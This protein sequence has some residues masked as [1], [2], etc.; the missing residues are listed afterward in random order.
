MTRSF[1]AAFFFVAFAA[2]ALS[3]AM[4]ADA[5]TPLLLQNPTISSTQIA[6]T[7]GGNIWTVPRDGGNATR[8]VTGYDLEGAPYFS[9]DGST[10]AFSGTYDGITGVYVVPASGGEPVRLTSHPDGAI[11]VG[12]TPDGKNVLYRSTMLSTNDP[13]MLFTVPATGGYPTRLP[14]PEAETGSYSPDGSHLA[15]V[16]NFR[17]EPFWKGYRGGQTTPIYL[18]NLADSSIEK[19]PRDNSNDDTPMW[20]GKDVYFLS[21]RGGPITLYDY[22][23]AS[24]R[25]S[26]VFEN[27]GFDITGASAGPGAIVYSQFGDLHVYDLATHTAKAISV[28]IAAD[29]PQVRPHWERVGTHIENASISPSG[30]RAVFEAHG[31][32]FTVPVEHGDVRN[33]SNAPHTAN[34][35]PAWSP[36][37]KSIAYFSDASGEYKLEIRDQRGLVAPRSIDLGNSPSYFYGPTWSPDSK[38]IAYTDK[39]LN[40]YYVALDHPT[41]V[42]VT[43]SIRSGGF[44]ESW[45]PDSK[46][47]TYV[48]T[49]SNYLHAAFLY[50]LATGRN[51][52][53]TDGQ[54]DVQNPTFDAGGK[55]LYF[56]ASTNVAL[57]GQGFDMTSDQHPV[58]AN[59]YAMVLQ[60]SDPSPLQPQTADESTKPAA[61]GDEPGDAS[62]EPS[63][64]ASPSAKPAKKAAAKKPVPIAIDFDG[65]QQRIVA[66]P[67]EEANYVGLA[68]GKAGEFFAVAAP[69]VSNTEGPAALSV[70]KFDIATLKAA[71]VVSDING[72]VISANGQK[73]LYNQGGHWSVADTAHPVGPGNATALNTSAMEVYVDPPAEWRQMYHEVWR[74][75]RDFFYDPHYHGLDLHAA[76]KRFE[77]YLAGVTSRSDLNFL[78]REMLS[79]LSVGHM[80]VS[81]GTQ[82]AMPHINVGLLGAD[83][84]VENGRYRFTKI[85]RG[86]S[87]DPGVKAPLVGPGVNVSVGDYLVAVNGHHIVATDDLYGAFEETAG[88]QTVVTVS[89]QPSGEGA[90]DVTVVPIPSEFSLRNDEWI[91]GNRRKVDELSGGKLGYVYLPDTEYAGFTDFNRYFFAAVGKQGVIV[92]ER[93]NHGGQL[94]DYIVDYLNRKPV[95]VEQ[96]RDGA[97]VIDPPLAI[98]GPKVMLINQYAGSGGDALPWLF[99]REHV[100]TLVGVRTWGGLV[101]IGG[102]PPLIDGGSVTAPRF[103]IGGLHGQW[104]VENHGVSPDIEVMQD[105]KLVREGHDP[106]LEAG[107]A[108]ALR[109]LREHPVPTY[110]HPPYPDHKPVLPPG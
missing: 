84:A 87:W 67:L 88:K 8:L 12:W 24:K 81:G 108:E 37:G 71:P 46:Y 53:I 51:V 79:Y 74:I 92:D 82:P 38:K 61:T 45:S 103:A 98:F 83:Y 90:H 22:D 21:D 65:L 36:D 5:A 54:S 40:L 86:Q 9:P 102:Y 52:Q 73:L 2:C 27:T 31:Q 63:A 1:L 104:E 93:F 14:L 109:Q 91:D 29:L 16:P 57:S 32:I 55:Y 105:P 41:P 56:T 70:Q 78:F 15:Y 18:A 17:Y 107:V 30:V 76:E 99:H 42:K 85:Y 89:S 75:E 100:G 68:A 69:L 13:D 97:L 72:A 58:S 110:T 80:F 3:N 95:A 48:D 66:L 39:H 94:A 62:P 44:E 19:V 49:L 7:Y 106:Q 64:S 96:E 20:V 101:G 47:L 60:K 25:V 43:S 59:V 35:D 4:A 28:G 34:R 50:D 23:T 77:P 33:I 6:F 10:V 26:R 11:A